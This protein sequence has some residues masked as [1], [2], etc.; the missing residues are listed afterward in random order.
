LDNFFAFKGRLFYIPLKR[1]TALST[2]ATATNPL[3]LRLRA[4]RVAVVL[5]RRREPALVVLYLV[6]SL[7][8]AL[9]AAL[10]ADIAF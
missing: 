4:L 6:T 10:S 2:A 8:V 3:P 7:I 9:S 5:G 1:A